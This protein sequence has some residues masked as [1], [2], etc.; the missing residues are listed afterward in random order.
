MQLSNTTSASFRRL[1][2]FA[3]RCFVMATSV[4]L[5]TGC[6]LP[7]AV[8]DATPSV[9]SSLASTASGAGKL[10]SS[11]LA[12]SSLDESQATLEKYCWSIRTDYYHG[13][14]GEA[15]VFKLVAKYWVKSR[16]GSTIVEVEAARYQDVIEKALAEVMADVDSL[17]P[18]E[19]ALVAR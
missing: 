3:A 7:S 9:L 19:R 14:S 6:S 16:P 11:A 12:D 15:P 18:W 4:A 2:R 10:A 1:L 17:D 13:P 8:H 5:T